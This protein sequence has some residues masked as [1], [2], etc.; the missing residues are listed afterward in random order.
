MRIENSWT[1]TEDLFMDR[2]PAAL[3][4]CSVIPACNPAKASVRAG[5]QKPAYHIPLTGK[6][7]TRLLFS[8]SQRAFLA[9]N[10]E[11]CS[12]FLVL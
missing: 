8:R 1:A 11:Y 3:A 2:A 5:W 9:E 7:M 4:F 10:A 12:K 6:G